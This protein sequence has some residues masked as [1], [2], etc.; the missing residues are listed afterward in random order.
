MRGATSRL[1]LLIKSRGADT[2]LQEHLMKATGKIVL[3]I[4]FVAIAATVATAQTQETKTTTETKTEI[5]GGK[6]LTVTGCVERGAGSDYVLTGVKQDGGKGPTRYALVTKQDLS[7]NLG[8]RVEIKGKAVTDGH[9]TVSVESKTKTE[10]GDAP[11]KK[12][13]T[14]TA[15]TNGVLDM[16]F[17]SV[18]TIESRSSSCN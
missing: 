12:T 3:A 6:D 9:G 10:V 11:D 17:L 16:P 2:A 5:K 1:G 14:K 13:T 4:G 7:Q 8:H 18:T 15:G